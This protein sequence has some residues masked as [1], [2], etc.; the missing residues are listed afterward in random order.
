MFVAGFGSREGFEFFLGDMGV[1]GGG[2][3]GRRGSPEV[4]WRSHAILSFKSW[5]CTDFAPIRLIGFDEPVGFFSR[6]IVFVA[7][8]SVP[9]LALP[10]G[11]DGRQ[12]CS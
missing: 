11:G 9:G 12:C 6:Q 1:E 3:F 5:F 7:D 10:E 4:G 8:V 2:A